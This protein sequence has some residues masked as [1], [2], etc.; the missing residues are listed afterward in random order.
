MLSMLLRRIHAASVTDERGGVMIVVAIVMGAFA[1]LV[2]G[3][4]HV[5]NWYTH[6]RHLQLQTDAAAFAAGQRFGLC[7]AGGG[8]LADMQAVADKFGGFTAGAFNPQVGTDTTGSGV[9]YSGTVQ[10]VYNSQAYPIGS[11][12]PDDPDTIPGDPCAEPQ[13]FDVKATETTIP[14]LFSFLPLGEVN[15][16]SRV[17]LKAI[18]EMKGLLPLA[19]PDVRP[20]YAFAH[21]L[22]AGGTEIASVQLTKG[23]VVANRQS[24]TGTTTVPVPVGDIMV[25]IR[26]VGSTNPGLPCGQLYTECYDTD[27]VRGWDP[28]TPAPTVKDVWILPGSCVPDAYYAEDDCAAGLQADVD[29]G[30]LTPVT[31]ATRVWAKVDGKNTKYD[32]S[33]SGLGTGVIRWTVTGGIPLA[34]A[35]PHPIS[36]GWNSGAGGDKSFGVVHTAVVGEPGP[37]QLVQVAEGGSAGA[38]T[39]E[40]GSQTLEVRIQTLG[41]LLLSGPADP[42]IYLRMFKSTGGSASQNQSLDCD[43]D[44]STI[45]D[46][47]AQGCSPFYIKNPGLACPYGNA[48]ALWNVWYVDNQSLPCVNLQ[49]GA[50]VGQIRQGLNERIFGSSTGGTC[51]AGPVNWRRGTG[52][53]YDANPEDRRAL[54]LIVTPLGTFDGTGSDRV[55][56]IDFGYFYV[57]GYS[58]DPCEGVDPNQDPVP[59]NRGAYV[60]GHFI[61][62]FPL[63]NVVPSDELCDFDSITPCIGVLTR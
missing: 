19:V 61:K 30:P 53:D 18:N 43:R 33:P 7:V 26:L 63:E 42:P 39:Q 27:H 2:T 28:A 1:L 35:G 24:W 38:N 45:R 29:L 37:L 14:R 8:A 16:H 49:L 5:G 44:L 9:S 62:F 31:G 52:F 21:F 15:A 6:R 34:G 58:N 59:N 50:S 13:M 3:S 22:D 46:E 4:L 11:D 48:S 12:H 25:R 40:T 23:A 17:E 51:S 20:Q 54:P 55:P 32:L 41:N 10:R 47:L 57:T 60:R 56:V 36:L